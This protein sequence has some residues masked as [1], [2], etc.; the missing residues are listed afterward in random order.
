MTTKNEHIEEWAKIVEAQEAEEK[1]QLQLLCEM[2]KVAEFNGYNLIV[3]TNDEGQEP[4]FHVTKGRNPTAPD[5]DCCIKFGSAE[6]FPHSGHCDKMPRKH[7]KD[8]VALLKSNDEDAVG[9]QTFWQSLIGDW[10]RN[11]NRRKIPLTTEMPDY[12]HIV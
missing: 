11:N 8:L 4:H 1:G 2:S 5:F 9:N 6:Y 10:N 7:L 12:I 3:W